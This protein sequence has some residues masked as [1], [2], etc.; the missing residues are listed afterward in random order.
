M[1]IGF[2]ALDYGCSILS[3]KAVID[4]VK[5]DIFRF[6]LLLIWSWIMLNGFE[7]VVALVSGLSFSASNWLL[8]EIWGIR[9]KIRFIVRF[10]ILS[11]EIGDDCAKTAPDCANGSLKK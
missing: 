10:F 4:L 6:R 5:A 2:Q 1:S 7:L 8:C 11:C 3:C 9:A